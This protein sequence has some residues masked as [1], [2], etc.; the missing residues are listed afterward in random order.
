MIYTLLSTM[1]MK[2]KE[3]GV[4]RDIR[5]KRHRNRTAPAALRNQD[6]MALS[7]PGG[8]VHRMLEAGKD[9]AAA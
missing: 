2:I 8:L 9:R 1:L 6:I 3:K 7:Q 4:G 5:I